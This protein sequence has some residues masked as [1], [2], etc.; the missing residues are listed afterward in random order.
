MAE[1]EEREEEEYKPIGKTLLAG[2]L[3]LVVVFAAWS[4]PFLRFDIL[5]VAMI[6]IAFLSR[7]DGYDAAMVDSRNKEKEEVP[8]MNVESYT[9]YKYQAGVLVELIE[10]NDKTSFYGPFSNLAE[11]H[12]W[13]ATFVAE[14][15]DCRGYQV[16]WMNT[17]IE[18]KKD[19][20]EAQSGPSGT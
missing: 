9:K 13:A 8:T 4:L 18:G 16:H 12:T 5:I 14:D 17:P 11:A 3:G 19:G 20:V 15:V 6:V 2:L 10:W 7:Q 1:T